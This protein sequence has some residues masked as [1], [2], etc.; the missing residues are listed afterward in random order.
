MQHSATLPEPLTPEARIPCETDAIATFDSCS[1]APVDFLASTYSTPGG[2][3]LGVG[4]A[5]AVA[6]A[7]QLCN[8]A[9]EDMLA[10]H[11]AC[12]IEDAAA[13]LALAL[14]PLS[15]SELQ[16]EEVAAA[17]RR[18]AQ[19][20]GQL[21]QMRGAA[22]ML[23]ETASPEKPRRTVS[24]RQATT[25]ARSPTLGAAARHKPAAVCV[26]SEDRTFRSTLAR[27]PRGTSSF[28]TE[29]RDQI[30]AR[31]N[32]KHSSTP[33]PGTYGSSTTTTAMPGSSS[34]AAAVFSDRLATRPAEVEIEEG[35]PPT[36]GLVA[37]R[38]DSANLTHAAADA[39]RDRKAGSRRE[40]NALQSIAAAHR[41]GTR[42]AFQ[43]AIA[44]ASTAGL[45]AAV[46][47]L[48]QCSRGVESAR[49][50]MNRAQR[51]KALDDIQLALSEAAKFESLRRSALY[52][53][54]KTMGRSSPG[55][56][57]YHSH[58]PFKLSLSSTQAL[59]GSTTGQSAGW[60]WREIKGLNGCHSYTRVSAA[61]SPRTGSGSHRVHVGCG[62]TAPKV[63]PSW[64]ANI[65]GPGT[66]SPVAPAVVLPREDNGFSVW[67][68]VVGVGRQKGWARV[69]RSS[70]PAPDGVLAFPR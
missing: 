33:G 55:P 1:V 44:Q 30:A 21:V 23:E 36:P 54:L 46:A 31:H 62:T 10:T 39:R 61:T 41:S 32:R 16:S 22:R 20:S 8:A 45:E 70:S 49:E 28:A 26:P 50:L 24:A 9:T 60:E 17:R 14:S 19:A 69:E 13:T 47:E 67:E 4:G 65:P 52:Q 59:S 58:D 25:P 27:S 38:V 43:R 42:D 64:R 11:A 37:A 3:R 63:H 68:E 53:H 5:S 18:F 57:Q 7:A 48:Q 66:Y 51:T 29:S 40:A 34:G 15:A 35:E 56:G 2:W 12:S 6:T